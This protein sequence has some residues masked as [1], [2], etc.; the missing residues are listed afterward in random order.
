LAISLLA[1]FKDKM[2]YLKQQ[3]AEIKVFFINSN[4]QLIKVIFPIFSAI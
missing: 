2:E 3:N 1:Y 4:D